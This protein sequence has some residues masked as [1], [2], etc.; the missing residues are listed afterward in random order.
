MSGTVLSGALFVHQRLGRQVQLDQLVHQ[1]PM[2][3]LDQL[4]QVELREQ[5]VQQVQLV[6]VELRAQLDQLVQRE[7]LEHQ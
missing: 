7:R 6:Q 2:V 3:K 5:R 1:V 4:V